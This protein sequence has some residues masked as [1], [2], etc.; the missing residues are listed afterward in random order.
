MNR[1]WARRGSGG[2]GKEWGEVVA[3]VGGVG[4]EISFVAIV[5]ENMGKGDAKLGSNL[6]KQ[7]QP[8]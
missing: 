3:M 5:S 4:G 7:N 1:G 6:R 2:N 8:D